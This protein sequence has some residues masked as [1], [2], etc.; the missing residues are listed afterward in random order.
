MGPTEHVGK[1]ASI[2]THVNNLRRF[3]NTF[4]NASSLIKPKPHLEVA[5][6]EAIPTD[7]SRRKAALRLAS[8]AG[9]EEKVWTDRA[10]FLMSMLSVASTSAATGVDMKQV[11]EAGIQGSKTLLENA[12]LKRQLISERAEKERLMLKCEKLMA[13]LDLEKTKA[14]DYKALNLALEQRIAAS[15]KHAL[16]STSRMDAGSSLSTSPLAPSAVPISGAVPPVPAAGTGPALSSVLPTDPLGEN[17]SLIEEKSDQLFPAAYVKYIN[18]II[19][20]PDG[21]WLATGDSNSKVTIWDMTGPTPSHPQTFSHNGTVFHIAWSP[22]SKALISASLDHSASVWVL[23]D[24]SS[25][26]ELHKNIPYAV[27][28]NAVCWSP[29]GNQF[30]VGTDDK[31]AVVYSFPA[32]EPVITLRGHNQPTFSLAWSP[33]GEFVAGGSHDTS[34]LIWKVSTGEVVHKLE[35]HTRWVWCVGWSP[36]GKYFASCSSDKTLVMYSA[37]RFVAKY[38]VVVIAPTP[39][40]ARPQRFAWHPSGGTLALTVGNGGVVCL[41][42]A[43]T[44]A[45]T[46]YWLEQDG[47]VASGWSVDGSKLFVSASTVLRIH[48]VLSGPGCRLGVGNNPSPALL[49]ALSASI[50]ASTTPSST[51]TTSTTAATSSSATT[52]TTTTTT[53]TSAPSTPATTESTSASLIAPST[54]STASTPSDSNSGATASGSS[55]SSS[56]ST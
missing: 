50:S 41:V 33:C 55:S 56:S 20:S 24:S 43:A 51:T 35:S 52:T 21:K 42:N 9:V 31:T 11:V 7:E 46:Q 15:R 23:N 54:S 30:A 36:C 39:E 25:T 18:D 12:D 49:Q 34:V 48:R 4:T 8:S 37:D 3:M 14:S 53:T 17:V 10:A 27:D 29:D 1:P 44:G 32:C 19:M 45:I 6:S 38:K 26:F 16:A 40:R 5:L 47:P 13:E 2:Y 28:A 22:N